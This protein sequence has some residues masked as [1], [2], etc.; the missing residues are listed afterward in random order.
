V[1]ATPVEV[2]DWTKQ[3][4]SFSP[5]MSAEVA[6]PA[7]T[8]LDAVA[9]GLASQGYKIKDRT[10]EGF[11]A[12]HRRLVRGLLGLAT[13]NDADIL[14]RTLLVVG[15]APAGGGSLLTISVKSGGQHRQ[16]IRRGAAGLTAAF[17]E[18]QRRGVG[19]TATPWQKR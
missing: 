16:G 15:A 13:A 8:A 6:A 3:A 12:S 4:K 17:Q 11:R 14:D 2:G 19:V 10:A 1:T 18:L 5:T 9:A 7:E